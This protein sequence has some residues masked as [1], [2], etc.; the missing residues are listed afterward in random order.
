MMFVDWRFGLVYS[1]WEL[2]SRSVVGICPRVGRDGVVV[3]YQL[4]LCY[5]LAARASGR[6]A[7][8]WGYRLVRDQGVPLCVSH[9]PHVAVGGEG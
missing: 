7:A 2:G 1:L 4:G 6:W 3:Y 5:G 8:Q 9:G